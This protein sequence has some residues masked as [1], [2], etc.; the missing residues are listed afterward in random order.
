[1][2]AHMLEANLIILNSVSWLHSKAC[3]VIFRGR[4]CSQAR[5]IESELEAKNNCI[6]KA[7]LRIRWGSHWQGGRAAWQLSRYDP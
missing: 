5:Q 7:L 3:P 2:H 4:Y 1:M 6:W